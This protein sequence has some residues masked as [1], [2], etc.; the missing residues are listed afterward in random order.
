MSWWTLFYHLCCHSLSPRYCHST[1]ELVQWPACWPSA[2]TLVPLLFIFNIARIIILKYKIDNFIQNVP[3][4]SHLNQKALQ[5]PTRLYHIC[6]LPHSGLILSPAALHIPIATLASVIP[7]THQS[8]SQ[9]RAFVLPLPFAPNSSP[10]IFMA[11]SF[12]SCKHCLLTNAFPNH[13]I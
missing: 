5:W 4:V 13:P 11:Q 3:V 6:T 7:K 9:L 12:N 10:P 8:Q 2:A 1:P